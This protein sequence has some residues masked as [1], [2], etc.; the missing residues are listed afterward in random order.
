MKINDCC[1]YANGAFAC[2]TWCFAVLHE[3]KS[4]YQVARSKTNGGER[5]RKSGLL[6]HSSTS[7]ILSNEVSQHLTIKQSNAQIGSPKM[8]FKMRSLKV[9]SA[10]NLHTSV[11]G[12][13]SILE[14]NDKQL[15]HELQLSWCILESNK[16]KREMFCVCV[17][18]L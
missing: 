15:I 1:L 8:Q 11:L 7:F 3:L 17:S 2:F 13:F 9:K 14:M 10:T 18:H 16:K 5:S 6:S 12:P 4:I